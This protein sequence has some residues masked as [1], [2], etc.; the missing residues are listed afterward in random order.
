MNVTA[1]FQSLFFNNNALYIKGLYSPIFLSMCLM[2]VF[3][4]RQNM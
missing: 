4:E 1:R 3:S 2:K